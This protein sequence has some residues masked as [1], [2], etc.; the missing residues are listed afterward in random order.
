MVLIIQRL[1]MCYTILSESVRISMNCKDFESFN[2]CPLDF[3]NKDTALICEMLFFIY[4]I[5]S[6]SEVFCYTCISKTCNL[7]LLYYS[8]FKVDDIL[9]MVERFEFW[10]HLVC[11]P[12]YLA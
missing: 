11:L 3:K 6:R 8:T 10:L 12:E 2:S 1:D 9:A 5:L 7:I 4:L